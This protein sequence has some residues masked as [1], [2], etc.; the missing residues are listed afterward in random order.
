MFL[1]SYRFDNENSYLVTGS[2]NPNSSSAELTYRPIESDNFEKRGFY[3]KAFSDD[4][5]CII[6]K[7]L[8]RAITKKY[9]GSRVG[10][11]SDY[12]R[13]LTSDEAKSYIFSSNLAA[14]PNRICFASDY[15]FD[16]ISNDYRSTTPSTA[17]YLTYG[18]SR[19]PVSWRTMSASISSS[20]LKNLGVDCAGAMPGS[21]GVLCPA[22]AITGIR[23]VM[24]IDLNAFKNI[25][26]DGQFET[27]YCLPSN[28]SASQIDLLECDSTNLE[29]L[30]KGYIEFGSFP[31]RELSAEEVEVVLANYDLNIETGKLQYNGKEY[32]R[33]KYPDTSNYR[34]YEVEPIK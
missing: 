6:Q 3:D 26:G 10:N 11:Y 23:P 20:I 31:Q 12:V 34:Y 16:K 18:P 14:D 9:D 32:V 17:S 2:K 29:G 19:Y 30:Q 15:S 13:L 5:R 33:E 27:P 24:T 22:D 1:N 21:I 25:T 4:E 28:F 8:P 7:A